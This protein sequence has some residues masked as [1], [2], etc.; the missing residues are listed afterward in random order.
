MTKRPGRIL[1]DYR[2]KSE[3]SPIKI[4]NKGISKM[5]NKSN[6]NT[7]SQDLERAYH[8]AGQFYIASPKTWINRENL[9]ENAKPILIPN[10]RVQDIDDEDDWKRAELLHKMISKIE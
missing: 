8:D 4:D 3:R 1:L 9:F 5:F 10:W 6:F 2:V 7:R